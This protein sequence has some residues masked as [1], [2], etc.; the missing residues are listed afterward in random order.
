MIIIPRPPGLTTPFAVG[1]EWVGGWLLLPCCVRQRR[2]VFSWDG[3][4]ALA[5]GLAPALGLLGFPG[6][7][8]SSLSHVQ[9]RQGR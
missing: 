8:L 6:A 5:L 3:H 1:R 7:G 2:V 9:A 4:G